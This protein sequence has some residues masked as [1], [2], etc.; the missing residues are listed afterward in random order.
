MEWVV[1]KYALLFLVLSVSGCVSAP[2]G[3]WYKPN[4]TLDEYSKVNYTCLQ[5]SQQPRQTSWYNSVVPGKSHSESES[6][7]ITNK[8]LFNACM[9]ANGF[10]WKIIEE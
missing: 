8:D 1:K 3:R 9:N 5:Q 2:L 10:Y 7:I 6:T 4:S